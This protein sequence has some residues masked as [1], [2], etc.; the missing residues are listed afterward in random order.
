[1]R[2]ARRSRRPTSEDICAAEIP[3]PGF[4]AEASGAQAVLTR[5][6]V[7]RAGVSEAGLVDFCHVLLN[8]NR[9]LYVE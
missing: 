8:S 6:A 3:V 5:P 1:V 7:K 4:F 9:F 2:R